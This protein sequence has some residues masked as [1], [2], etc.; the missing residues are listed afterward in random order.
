VFHSSYILIVYKKLPAELAFNA[1]WPQQL[2]PPW[3]RHV[4][5]VQNY[6]FAGAGAGGAAGFGSALAGSA[7]FGSAFLPASLTSMVAAFMV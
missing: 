6:F 4:Y 1:W 7:F 5:S 2:G 3:K